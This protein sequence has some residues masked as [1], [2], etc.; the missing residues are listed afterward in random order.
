MKASA[1]QLHVQILGQADKST[2][3]LPRGAKLGTQRINVGGVVGE[4]AEDGLRFRI[5]VVELE[6]LTFVVKCD[7]CNS[8]LAAKPE[9]RDGFAWM[10]EDDSF[11]ADA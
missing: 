9:G 4:D 2:K 10:S 6:E 1:S 7:Q 11:C 8:K 5:V 3:V